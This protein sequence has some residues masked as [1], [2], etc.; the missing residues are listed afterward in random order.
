MYSDAHVE[1][2]IK[3]NPSILKD[4]DAWLQQKWVTSQIV[5][6]KK[7]EMAQCALVSGGLTSL[8][9]YTNESLSSESCNP[10]TQLWLNS[11]LNGEI[12]SLGS[13]FAQKE[14]IISRLINQIKKIDCVDLQPDINGAQDSIK[15]QSKNKINLIESNIFDIKSITH[16]SKYDFV[17]CNSVLYCLED[18]EIINLL[19]LA[20]DLLKPGGKLILSDQ[21]LISPLKIFRRNLFPTR[22]KN[23][24]FSGYVRSKNYLKYI[25]SEYSNRRNLEFELKNIQPIKKSHYY[26]TIG[27]KKHSPIHYNISQQ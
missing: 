12:I 9:Q 5:N 10:I 2:Y 13:G 23:Y 26:F 8:P 16:S 14:I 20:S 7:H 3:S 25:F 15:K 27:Y 24:K 17:L 1:S 6:A 21:N 4:L 18:N 19:D 22:N 11:N